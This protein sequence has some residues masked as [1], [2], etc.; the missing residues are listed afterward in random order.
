MATLG[1]LLTPNHPINQLTTNGVIV[2]RAEAIRKY[3]RVK[4]LKGAASKAERDIA[5][6]TSFLPT[7]LQRH[8]NY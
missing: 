8:S 2:K 3:R 4:N 6:I 7:H 5:I 1:E